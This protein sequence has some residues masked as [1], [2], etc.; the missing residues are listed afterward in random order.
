MSEQNE[1]LLDPNILTLL[2]EMEVV[3]NKFGIDYYVAGAFAR[4]IQFQTKQPDSNFRKTN[5]VDLAVCIN[6]EDHYN[7]VMDALVATNS[8]VRDEKEIIKLHYRL[9]IEVD[10]I[11][12]GAIEDEKRNVK[13]SKPKAFTLQMPG[14]AEAAAFTEEIKSGSLLL[15]T[16]SIEGLIM[17]KLISWDDRTERTHDLTDIDNIIDAYFNWNSDEIYSDH[18][19]VMEKYDTNDLH[20]YMPKISAHI[21][22]LKM[23]LLLADSTELF[24]RVKKILKK[25]TNPRWE[26]LL[27]GLNEK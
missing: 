20:F 6:H 22:G 25:K 3:F 4:D 9:G 17:L 21:I 12:F 13:L 10:L 2:T 1:I 27:N 15:R 18:F 24:Q 19:E 11:P 14:F 16:C 5:D 7:G 8:F 26:A 23:K